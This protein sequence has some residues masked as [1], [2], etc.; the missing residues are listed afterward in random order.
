MFKERKMWL[1]TLTLQTH[2]SS[3][4]DIETLYQDVV[5]DSAFS[6]TNINLFYHMNSV[7]HVSWHIQHQTT[8][9]TGCSVHATQLIEL[10]RVFGAVHQRSWLPAFVNN[11]QL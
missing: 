2:L 9:N 4:G 6:A 8:F 1:E 11:H 5:Q 10:L 7:L 3:K